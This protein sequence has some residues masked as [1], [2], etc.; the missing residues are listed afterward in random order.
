MEWTLRNS[1]REIRRRLQTFQNRKVSDIA[2]SGYL[3]LSNS[4]RATLIRSSN[5]R[6]ACVGNA[7]TR[8]VHNCNFCTFWQTP[9]HASS[10]LSCGFSLPTWTPKSC[11]MEFV[12]LLVEKLQQDLDATAKGLPAKHQVRVCAKYHTIVYSDTY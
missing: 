9:S 11:L 1:P 2:R 12:P 4:R 10:W 7:G 3:L 8:H 6:S 5:S